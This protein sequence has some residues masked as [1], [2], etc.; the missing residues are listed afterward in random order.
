MVAAIAFLFNPAVILVSSIWGQN[1]SVAALALVAAVYCLVTTRTEAGMVAAVL[2][3]P[4]KFQYGFAVP[5]VLIVGLRRNVA[6]R[7][8]GRDPN[9]GIDWGPVARSI[10]AGVATAVIVCWPFGLAL[11]DPA[12]PA[13]SLFARFIAAFGAFP[14]ITQN[15]FNVWMNPF[16]PV[17]IVGASGLTEGHVVDDTA[18][19]LAVAGISMTWQGIG[20]LLF[21]GAVLTALSVLFRRTDGVAILFVALVIAVAFFALPTRVHERYLYPALALGVPL[22]AAGIRWRRLYVAMSAVAFLNVYWVYSLPIGNAGPGRGILGDTVYSAAGI[23][24]MSAIM[25]AGLA[26]LI[27]VALRPGSLARADCDSVGD[28]DPRVSPSARR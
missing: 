21:A 28:A 18:V 13:H 8:E 24:V 23:Y 9:S 25:V 6:R 11:F 14:G 3:M 1:D 2:A 7:S 19:A 16:F 15:A 22:L 12:N 17:V 4:V 27:I 20:N 26:S 5:I 10:V